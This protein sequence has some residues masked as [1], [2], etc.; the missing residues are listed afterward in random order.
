MARLSTFVYGIMISVA[1]VSIFLTAS[2]KLMDNYNTN[3]PTEYND[4]FTTI[5]DF[6]TIEDN[7]QDLK[8]SVLSESETSKIPIIG[9]A[10][11]V[12]GKYF[13]AGVK[14]ARLVASYLNV[15]ETL[16]TETLD[17]NAQFLGSAYAPIKALIISLVAVL[18]LFLLIGVYLRY[19][20]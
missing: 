14:S 9:D 7:T 5:S 12:L 8:E 3:I 13:E 2:I 6:S 17:K 11:D 19:K 16:A 18:I 20:T 10:L 4:S 15:F 1:I